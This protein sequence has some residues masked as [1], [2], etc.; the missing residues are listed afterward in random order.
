MKKSDYLQRPRPADQR[1]A[2]P[3]L[4]ALPADQRPAT[5][6]QRPTGVASGTGLPAA[7]L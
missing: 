3:A 6:D 1:P 7:L 5:S 4:P 2:L